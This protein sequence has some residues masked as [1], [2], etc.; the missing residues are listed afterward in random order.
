MK[1]LF[2]LKSEVIGD[3]RVSVHRITCSKCNHSDTMTSSRGGNPFPAEVVARHFRF[4]GWDIS[5]REGEDICPLCVE[6][7]KVAR[8]QA[9]LRIVPKKAEAAPAKEKANPM[10]AQP[11]EPATAPAA[12]TTLGRDERRIIFGT[13]DKVYI[14][15]DKGYQPGWNDTRVSN[16]LGVP[17]VWVR[18]IRE[19]MFGPEGESAEVRK[20]VEAMNAALKEAHVVHDDLMTV[21]AKH[22]ELAEQAE[23]KAG[24]L[25]ALMTTLSVQA[26]RLTAALK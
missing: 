17:V 19:E 24:N 21:A 5:D 1:R 25:A 11:A 10:P 20:A 22:R 2:R 13:L 12:P 14:D 6:K 4:K 8:R 15:A 3:H 23:E 18:D 16:D 7:E 26:T 9:R